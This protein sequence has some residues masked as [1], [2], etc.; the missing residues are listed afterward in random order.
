VKASA[1]QQACNAGAVVVVSKA[2]H[3]PPVLPWGLAN[4]DACVSGG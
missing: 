1:F 2:P 4:F 3:H